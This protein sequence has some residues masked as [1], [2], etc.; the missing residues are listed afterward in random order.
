VL[1]EVQLL[2]LFLVALLVLLV[3][4][5]L[6]H[7][8]AVLVE[9]PKSRAVAFLVEDELELVVVEGV[10]GYAVLVGGGV[11][12]GQGEKRVEADPKWG[13]EYLKAFSSILGMILLRT[14]QLISRQGLV[15]ISIS[16]G[17]Q[18]VSSMKSKPKI[19]KLLPL[20]W[21][22]MWQKVALTASSA[23]SF[24]RG[25][26]SLPRLGGCTLDRAKVS[27]YLWSSE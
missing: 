14:G 2:P 25:Q 8:R 19:S 10:F 4:V 13:E 6:P 17:R 3:L 9:L 16:Q 18:L 5:H 23:I 20:R 12:E 15:L 21:G 1:I 26:M 7:H 22:S 27:R 24:N 11:V